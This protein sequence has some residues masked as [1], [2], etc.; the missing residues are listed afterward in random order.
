MYFLLRILHRHY[1]YKLGAE[2]PPECTIGG[3]FVMGHTQGIVINGSAV[4]GRNC[5]VMSGVVIGSVRGK[6]GGAP[7][8]GDNVVL[9]AGAKIIGNVTIGD[10]VMVGAGAVVTKDV[11]N[12]STVVG[13]PARVINNDGKEQVSNYLIK[14]N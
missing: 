4:I 11:P 1:Q 8:I 10:N 13:V 7:K 3:G 2:I 12:N 6:K 5:T 14:Y 9:S